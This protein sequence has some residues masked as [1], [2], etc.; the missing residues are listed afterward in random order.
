MDEE[1][2]ETVEK[3]EAEKQCRAAAQFVIIATQIGQT[4]PGQLG[5]RYV[6]K[7]DAL[8]PEPGCQHEEDPD[9][10]RSALAGGHAGGNLLIYSG[11][12][13]EGQI[14]E[15]PTPAAKVARGVE[16]TPTMLYDEH[17]LSSIST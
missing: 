8:R 15:V 17:Q 1:A 16:T 4:R 5:H 7:A 10:R 9:S 6:D 14:W 2:D 12:Q 11:A 3:E 13:S